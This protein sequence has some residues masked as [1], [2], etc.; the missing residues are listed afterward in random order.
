VSSRYTP[1]PGRSLE[2]LDQSDLATRRDVSEGWYV[3]D[4]RALPKVRSITKPVSAFANT[5]GGWLFQGGQEKDKSG[6]VY[7]RPADGSEP[8][9]ETDQHQ[10]DLLFTR[11]EK[12]DA[13][14]KPWIDHA[15][16]RAKGEDG[17]PYLCILLEADP[18][19]AQGN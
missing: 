1:F 4:K 19:A 5:Y 11:R 15:P 14:Y 7:R 8:A 3:E 10:L 9:S 13:V 17:S 12:I 6:A 16:E 2:Q 18:Y